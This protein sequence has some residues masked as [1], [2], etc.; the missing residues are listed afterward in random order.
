MGLR[1][2]HDGVERGWVGDGQFAQH[3][4]IEFDSGRDEGGDETVV[5]DSAKTQARRPGG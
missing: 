2:F 5:T 4:A 3:L 1:L